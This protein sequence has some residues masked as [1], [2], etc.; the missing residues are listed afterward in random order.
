MNNNK[1]FTLIEIILSLAILGIVSVGFLYIISNNFFILNKTKELSEGTFKIQQEMEMIIDEVKEGVRDG[2]TSIKIKDKTISIKESTNFIW[3]SLDPKGSKVKY[4][5]V[6][7]PGDKR[8][9]TLVSNVKPRIDTEILKLH[10][11]DI[12]AKKDLDNVKYAYD[13]AGFS[14]IGFFEN[15]RDVESKYNHLLNIVEWYVASER[16][17]MPL[18]SG[19][20]ADEQT[21]YY[22]FFP[23]DYTLIKNETV[24]RYGIH[25]KKLI[26]LKDYKGRHIIFTATPGAKSGKIGEQYISNPVFISGIPMTNNLAIHLDAN[27]ID[28]TSTGNNGE[29]KNINS[30]LKVNK[31]TDISSVFNNIPANEFAI[32]SNDNSKPELK[33]TNTS[34]EY[35]GQFVQFNEKQSLSINNQNTIHK[36]IDIFAV[37]R[38]RGD[39]EATFIKN[40]ENMVNTIINEKNNG[41]QI[42]RTGYK[43]NSNEFII[44]KA[45]VDIAEIIVFTSIL[46]DDENIEVENYL[47]LKYLLHDDIE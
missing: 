5:E 33:N 27:F 21:V 35:V 17:N 9:A 47:K 38:N 20:A 32:G 7:H 8:Y 23:R 45:N 10:S 13:A 42:I 14:I 6:V 19:I 24:D 43:S 44:G 12:L 29:V 41:W 15:A 36:D 1:G 30:V 3:K 46:N 40:N 34:T 16:F 39:D 22:P 31:W 26:D 11:I 28:P 37:V 25:E 4:F 18:P 2:K